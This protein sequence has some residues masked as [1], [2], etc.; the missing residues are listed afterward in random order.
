[1]R[2]IRLISIIIFFTCNNNNLVV[3]SSL[4]QS[5]REQYETYPYPTLE[6]SESTSIVLQSP[7]H[8][9]EMNHYIWRGRKNFCEKNSS[10]RILVAG[11]GTGVK[12]VQ[13]ATQLRDMNARKALVVHLDLSNHSIRVAKERSQRAGV[14]K[15]IQFVQGSIENIKDLNLGQ[16]DYIDCLGVLHHMN[17]PVHGLRELNAVRG[18]RARGVRAR[19]ARISTFLFTYSEYSLVSLTHHS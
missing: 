19:S 4:F 8:L 1:M 13:L 10:F 15:Y 6:S 9:I 18:V 11:G 12:T 5:T 17:D 2:L 3:E 7:S 16:F 14:E